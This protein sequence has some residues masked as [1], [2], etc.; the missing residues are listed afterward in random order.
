MSEYFLRSNLPARA[1]TALKKAG[2]DSLDKVLPLIQDDEDKIY[3]IR[4]IG[5]KYG[6]KIIALLVPLICA[7]EGMLFYNSKTKVITCPKCGKK[8]NIWMEEI[9]E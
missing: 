1:V 9:N 7:H 2:Y 6:A 5:K 4:G 8:F 3:T